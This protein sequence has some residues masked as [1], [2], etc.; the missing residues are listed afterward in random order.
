[1]QPFRDNKPFDIGQKE[2][3]LLTDFGE[4]VRLVIT[5]QEKRWLLGLDMRDWNDPRVCFDDRLSK[6]SSPGNNRQR[7]GSF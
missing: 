3:A 1:M 6:K 7:F 5:S 4:L 2:E